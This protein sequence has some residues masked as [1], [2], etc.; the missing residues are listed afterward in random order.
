MRYQSSAIMSRITD[1]T[2]TLISGLQAYFFFKLYCE[3]ESKSNF[4][5]SFDKIMNICYQK[6]RAAVGFVY[7]R[8]A[9]KK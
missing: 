7:F 2:A 3:M 5:N 4:G 8:N 9:P 6:K 1:H